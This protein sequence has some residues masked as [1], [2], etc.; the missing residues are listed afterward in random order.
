MSTPAD[1]KK[2]LPEKVHIKKYRIFPHDFNFSFQSITSMID[3]VTYRVQIGSFAGGTKLRSKFKRRKK[4]SQLWTS[5]GFTTETAI[6]VGLVVM[7]IIIIQIRIHLLLSGDV[8]LNPGPGT[9]EQVNPDMTKENELNGQTDT[10][11]GY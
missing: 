5:H 11:Q 3:I 9:K 7:M 10:P 2:K 6:Y 4:T 1:V 8:E